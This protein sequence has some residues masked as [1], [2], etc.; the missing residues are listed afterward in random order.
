MYREGRFYHS[1]VLTMHVLGLEGNGP[2]RVGV[3]AGKRIGSQA[4]RSVWKRRVRASI[5]NRLAELPEGVDL[6]FVLRPAILQAD[7]TRI[8][9][10]VGELLRMAGVLAG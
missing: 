4:K 7:F 8:D 9:A 6:I 1:G 10:A 3:V 5:G 2:A